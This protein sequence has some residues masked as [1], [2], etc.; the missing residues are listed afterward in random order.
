MTPELKAKWVEVLRSGEYEQGQETLRS[1]D[2]KFCCLG[3][4]LDFIGGGFVELRVQESMA[5]IRN[6][7]RLLQTAAGVNVFFLLISVV[8]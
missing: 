1:Y 2:N 7:S 3:V 5:G 8:R 6:S 4:L